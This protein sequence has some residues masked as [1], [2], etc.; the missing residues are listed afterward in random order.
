MSRK[1]DYR[2]SGG[3]P[4]SQGI[5]QSIIATTPRIAAAVSK[6]PRRALSLSID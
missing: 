5:N 2:H 3:R 4:A 1:E 6:S